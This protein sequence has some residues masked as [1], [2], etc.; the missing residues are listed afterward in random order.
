[1]SFVTESAKSTA[2]ARVLLQIH[3]GTRN[4]QWINVG[5]GIWYVN[6]D[7]LYPEVDATLLSGFTVQAFGD[8]GSVYV[9]SIQLEQKTSLASVT[10]GSFYYDRANREVHVCTPMYDDPIMHDIALGVVNGFSFNEFVPTGSYTLYE[11]RLRGSPSVSISRDPMF[12]GKL[13][14]DTGSFELIN[15]DGD[16]DTLATQD[17][18]GNEAR[19]YLGYDG[20]DISE[21]QRL[22]TGSVEAIKVGEETVTVSVTDKRKSLSRQIEYLC[23][24]KNAL[25]AIAEILLNA[26]GVTY[27]STYYDTTAWAAAQATAPLVTIKVGAGYNATS[28]SA[29]DMIENICASVPGVLLI[30]EAGLYSFKTIG[31][32]VTATT[33]I[34]SYDAI[35]RHEVSYDPTEVIS[36][37]RILYNH[38]WTGTTSD[39]AYTNIDHE[40]TAFSRYKVYNERE[41]ATWLHDETYAIPYS[42]TI[43]DYFDAVHGRGTVEVGMAYY[44]LEV[45]DSVYIE[46][47]RGQSTMIT[48]TECEVTGITYNLDK[49]TMTISYRMK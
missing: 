14:F 30:N 20:L 27:S 8:V 22:Y 4:V 2:P 31:A 15:T 32:T 35:G 12:F 34:Q 44:G 21:Y 46:F 18:Y 41:F 17:V 6:F 24:A 26:Y 38:D 37:C 5:A 16:L 39:N 49:P 25:D 28:M 40:A 42:E 3:I 19:V 47:T 10:A 1:M 48:T 33:T 9:D 13:Q 43:M 23:V 45:G 7:A 29:I 36:S 11:G